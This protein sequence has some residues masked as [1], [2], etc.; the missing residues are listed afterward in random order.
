MSRSFSSCK[1]LGLGFQHSSGSVRRLGVKPSCF[2]GHIAVL[3][4]ARTPKNKGKKLWGCPNFKGGGKDIVGC[5]FFQWCS[6]EGIEEGN[7]LNVE[8][9]SRSGRN[10]QVGRSLMMMEQ[11]VMKMEEP[12]VEKMKIACLEKSV[13]MLEKWLEVLLGWSLIYVFLM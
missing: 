8:E 13:V 7:V 12:D 5:N 2:C 3:H 4:I 9:R 6:E 10:E 1:C 11:S